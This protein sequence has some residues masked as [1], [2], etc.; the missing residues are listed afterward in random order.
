MAFIGHPPGCAIRFRQDGSLRYLGTLPVSPDQHAACWIALC[1]LHALPS[2]LLL[3]ALMA[4][5]PGNLPLAHLPGTALGVL[6]FATAV[7]L[8]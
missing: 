1:A 5:P 2:A 8:E 6:L 3:P 7:I 4:R